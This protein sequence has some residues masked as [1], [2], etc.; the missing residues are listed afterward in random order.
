VEPEAGP[1]N[2]V[3]LSAVAAAAGAFAA[4]GFLVV[5]DCVIRPWA[6]APFR[7]LDHPLHYVVLRVPVEEAVARCGTRTGEAL[8]DPAV[9]A[10]LHAQ[11]A[12]LGPLAGHRL[13][14]TGLGPEEVAGCLDAG[15]AEGRF[16]LGS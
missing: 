11:F 16:R 9:I 15:L 5:V 4:G 13:D 14:V 3:V 10:D 7:G 6:L 2:A 12:D 1:L 8:R